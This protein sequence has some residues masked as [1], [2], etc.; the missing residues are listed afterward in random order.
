MVQPVPLEREHELCVLATQHRSEAERAG[1]PVVLLVLPERRP[2]EWR[3]GKRGPAHEP[4][5]GIHRLFVR[6]QGD[7]EVVRQQLHVGTLVH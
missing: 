3:V 6:V 5:E 7:A 1:P 2:R 4:R